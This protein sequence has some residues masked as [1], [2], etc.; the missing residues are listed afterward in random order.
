MMA[1]THTHHVYAPAQT[2]HLRLSL[3]H[4]GRLSFSPTTASTG[5]TPSIAFWPSL[6]TRYALVIFG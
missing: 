4:D 1:K 6:K 3:V 2:G 5:A